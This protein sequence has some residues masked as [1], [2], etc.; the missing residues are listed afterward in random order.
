M[1]VEEYINIHFK[2]GPL[3]LVPKWDG[4]TSRLILYMRKFNAAEKITGL[5]TNL[6][7]DIKFGFS[8]AADSTPIKEEMALMI[9]CLLGPVT[10]SILFPADKKIVLDVPGLDLTPVVPGQHIGYAYPVYAM[11]PRIKID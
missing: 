6:D 5:F 11:R 8:T 9:T 10:K 7:L 1:S 3:G 4:N 2:K